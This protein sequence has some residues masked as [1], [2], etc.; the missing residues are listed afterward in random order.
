MRGLAAL[1]VVCGHAVTARPDL[2]ARSAG[3]G[4]L[5]ILASGVDIFFVISG[6]II[7]TTAASRSNAF[8]FALRRVVRIY[9]VYWLV[10]A[11]AFISSRWIALAPGGRPAPDLGLI[12]AWHYPN[13]YIA[14]AWSIVF[15]I[16]FY[17]IV[18]VILAVA[19]NR[20]FELLFVGLGVVVAAVAFHLPLGLYAHPLVL[21]FGAGVAIA[22]F[23]R[24]DGGLPF[25]PYIPVI[26][27]CL[28]AAG[29]YWI[30]VHG[31]SDPQSARVPTYG[32]GAALL[33]YA[34][35][36][37]ELNGASFP[38]ILQWFGNISYSLYIAHYLL[39]KW[40]A[41]FTGLWL[42]SPAAVII[43]SILLSIGLAAAIHVLVETP[44][45]HWGR[46][47]SLM[48]WTRPPKPAVAVQA[49]ADPICDA[50][51]A[52]DSRTMRSIPPR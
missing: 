36:S 9:P 28:F 42:I 4:A 13:W 7:A 37:A 31:S 3:E 50:M 30:F 27:A 43:A 18:A 40:I 2:T 48:D 20:L 29:W 19:P 16:H 10:L 15:E 12:F 14:P 49:N 51:A 34:V 26:S 22:Y 23:V 6:F 21:E 39:I 24:R 25:S 8:E 32:L 1:A 46:R 38:R 45:L 5:T 17:A 41:S 52:R 11:V 35:V 33:I 44:T 47:L